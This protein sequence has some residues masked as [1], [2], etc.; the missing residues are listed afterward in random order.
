MR[1]LGFILFI[2]AAA[3]PLRAGDGTLTDAQRAELAQYFGFGPMQIYKIKPGLQQLKIA[4]LDGDGRNDIAVVNSYQSRIELFYQ[5]GPNDKPTT[6]PTVLDPN[7]IPNRGDLRVENVSVAYSIASLEIADLTGDKR[8]DLVFFGEPKEVVILPGK[9]EGGFGPPDAVRAPDGNPRGGALALGDFNGDGRAD[10][11]LLGPEV[12]QIFHQ[13]PTGGLAA[14]VRLVHN[15]KAPLMMMRAD[16]NGDR[17]DDLIISADEDQAGAYVILQEPSG[18]LGPTR[19]ANIPKLRSVTIASGVGGDDLYSIESATGHL[20]HYRWTTDAARATEPDWPQLLYAYPV[21]SKSKRRPADIGD[22][23]G[24]K[25]PD[26]VVMDPDSAQLVLYASA[27]DALEPG[28]AFPGLVKGVDLCVADI[29]GDGQCEVL[30]VSTDE[31]M[32]GVSH[33]KDGRLSFPAPLPTQGEPLGV[34]VGA[35]KAGGTP[36]HLAYVT[37]IDKKP[38]LIIKPFAADGQMLPIADLPD[39]V[40]GLRFADVN[41]DGLS[42]LLLFVRFSPLRTFLQRNDGTFELFGGPQTREGLV[43][44][45][46]PEGFAMSDVTGDGKPEVLLVQKNL[47]RALRIESGQW[48]VVDQYNTEAAD[49]EIGGLAALPGSSVGSPVL[50]LYD[51]KSRDLSVLKRRE[52]NTYGVS[53]TMP[54]GSFELTLMSPFPVGGSGRT[55]LLMAHLQ[56]VA[57]LLPD[58]NAPTLVEQASFETNMKDAWLADAVVG[59]VNHDGVRDVMVVDLRKANIEILTTLPDGD[60]VSA[61]RF[62]VFQGKRFRDE[63]DS[64]GQPREVLCGDVTGDKIDDIVLIAHDRLIIYPGQ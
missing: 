37:R 34:A 42:D 53:R 26:L 43:A 14:P 61:T 21:R 23:T 15:I 35:L 39:D 17:R 10:V 30:S 60:L 36:T 27:G 7:E 52:D 11:A 59:D 44:T 6:K 25:R 48:T 38:N 62:Q 2:A 28:V 51:K 46:A 16:F 3:A 1:A 64:G 4:D 5:P 29:D 49:A 13:K 55:T 45:A 56:G 12:V 58:E 54:A 57:L 31:K 22:V 9:P 19:R 50:C 24:D 32:I 47:A 8:P 40:A 63:P 41:Q 20:R 33:F 18:T